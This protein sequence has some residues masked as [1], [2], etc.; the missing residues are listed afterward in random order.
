MPRFKTGS[1][2]AYIVGTLDEVAFPVTPQQSVFNFGLSHVDTD[3]V[4][5]LSTPVCALSTWHT[6]AVAVA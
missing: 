4:G 3:H 2:D 6:R 5:N 1:A